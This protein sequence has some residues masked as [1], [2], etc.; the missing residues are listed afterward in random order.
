MC[1]FDIRTPN[2]DGIEA[3]RPLAGP[4]VEDSIAVAVITTSD[5]F[6]TDE[7]VTAVC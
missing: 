3:T 2:L 4:D 1:L 5:T 7:Y 6:D